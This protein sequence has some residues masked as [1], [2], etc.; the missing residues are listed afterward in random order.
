MV[1]FHIP[2][3][4]ARADRRSVSGRR[5]MRTFKTA[6]TAALILLLGAAAVAAIAVAAMIVSL[7]T[8]IPT[9][10]E[11]T[12]YTPAEAT[13]IYSSDGMLLAKL[14]IENRKVVRLEEISPSLIDAT[15]AVEDSRFYEH[16][17]IDPRGTIRALWANLSGGDVAGQGGS[18]I[19]Q[20]L[21]RNVTR[22]GISRRKTLRRK[23]HEA[24]TAVRI[25]Q[26]LSKNEVLELYLNQI[27][28]GSGAY[29]VE[30][31]AR[32][33][34]DKPASQLTIAEAALLAGIPQRPEHNSPHN[35]IESARRRRS[36]VLRRMLDTGR[37]TEQQY[38]AARGEPIRL[39]GIRHANR[40]YRAPYFVNWV[41]KALEQ[42]Y[43]RDG[44]YSGL[45]VITSLNWK[46]Q[47]RAENV[48][49]GPLSYGATDAAL[50]SID[51]HTGCVRAMVGGR[52]Y[53]RNQ[54]NAV[55]Q[56]LRQPGSAFK[57][58]VYAAAFDTGTVDLSTRVRDEKLQL[59]IDDRNTWT[60]HNY[61][62]RYQNKERSVLDALRFSINTIAVNVGLQTG[63]DQIIRYA[64]ALGI[65]SELPP[66]PSLSLGSGAVRPIELCAAYGVFAANG[67]RYAPIGVLLVK[68]ARGQTIYRDNPAG[69]VY[70]TVLGQGTIDQINFA[71]R[72]AVLRGSGSLA[73][74][75]PNAY[76]KTG[77]TSDHRD[78]WFVGYTP[79]LVTAVWAAAPQKDRRGKIRFRVM[80][81]G[82]GGKVAAPLWARF[83]DTA[84]PLQRKI[85]ARRGRHWNIHLV[86][87]EV[88][89]VE[90][91][92]SPISKPQLAQSDAIGSSDLDGSRYWTASPPQMVGSGDVAIRYSGLLTSGTFFQSVPSNAGE[93]A[94]VCADSGG[95]AGEFCP[96]TV[97]RNLRP[98]E[99]ER[100]RICRRHRAPP[101]ETG[102]VMAE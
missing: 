34:F 61:A 81:G 86:K 20:Q 25:E 18:T 37:I 48:L 73:A 67:E 40:V 64:R 39:A 99:E 27:Y 29:G 9:I 36:I 95:L 76:G 10:S 66:W 38:N 44:L 54:F 56:G 90:D 22:F 16:N 41:V 24:M 26:A 52:S 101:G 69:R 14:Q 80:H 45:T 46:M 50:V 55:T 21:A 31:A 8:T 28:Y 93:G 89:P 19:T 94:P 5:H 12:S 65:N 57:P 78:T 62:E 6:F 2:F 83:M 42:A 7:R 88:E 100:S 58:I 71:L 23:L 35:R 51:P 1:T 79:D 17:G 77:T 72:E 102:L 98:E 3:P 60:V 70:P 53:R 11:I 47:E 59:V 13:K 82:T 96:V 84:A 91:Q 15:L 75:V 68:D 87:Y 74:R 49:R 97:M 33:Y 85:N 30:A 63:I 4:L 92:K 32:T 43:G